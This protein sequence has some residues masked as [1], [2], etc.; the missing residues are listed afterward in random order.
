MSNPKILVTGSHGQLASELRDCARSYPGYDF[1]FLSRENISICN[2]S[3]VKEYFEALRPQYC[4]NCAAYTAVDK[5]ESEPE[6]AFLVNGL[7]TGFL[8]SA[9]HLFQTKFIHISTDYVFN[10]TSDRPYNEEDP[11]DPVNVYGA[12][13]L[14]GEQLAVQYN[15]QTIVIRTSWL[16]STY[17]NNFVKSMIRLMKEKE[18]LNIVNDQHGSPTYAADLA[19]MIFKMITA[20][21]WNPGI[22]HFSN[23][24]VTTWFGLAEAIK[25]LTSS[26]CRINPIPTSSYPT[27]ARR[28]HYSAFNTGKIET[29]YQTTI[30]GWREGLTK[31]IQKLEKG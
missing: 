13:K 22:Y 9:S 11:V 28:P 10:G 1:I 29:V 15:D 2:E 27:L 31:C 21:K 23:K 8:A 20:A 17:G 6:T 14:K 7:A 4:I 24:G 26:D 30:P 18:S 3:S 19:T 12:S 5:A 16:F 25:Q